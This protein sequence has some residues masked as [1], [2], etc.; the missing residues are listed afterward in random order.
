M[1]EF[2]IGLLIERIIQIFWFIIAN[3][4]T[5][6]PL[7]GSWV[8]R[9]LYLIINPDEERGHTYVIATGLALLFTGYSISPFAKDY[10][11]AISIEFILSLGLA[12]Y[13]ILLIVLGLFK[14]MPEFLI[15]FFG[16]P[17]HV[18]IPAVLAI[19]YVTSDIP[20]DIAAIAAVA[21]P[22]VLAMILTIIFRRKS[23]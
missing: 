18:I 16:D 13:G 7:I 15:D 5:F 23:A 19:I 8:I 21:V 12:G 2:T 4:L 6:I 1:V 11:L 14:L 20:V 10:P 17:G 9:T 22:V 3:K